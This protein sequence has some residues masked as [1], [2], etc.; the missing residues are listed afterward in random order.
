[1]DWRRLIRLAFLGA[2][3]LVVTSGLAL[4]FAIPEV[5]G[6]TRAS[7]AFLGLALGTLLVLHG[8]RPVAL[9]LLAADAVFALGILAARFG[10]QDRLDHSGCRAGIPCDARI[11][12]REGLRASVF[13]TGLG[14]AVAV[15]LAGFVR[16]RRSRPVPGP[17]V[18]SSQAGS[19]RGAPRL[20]G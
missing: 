15:A 7:L 19:G 10:V 3:L 8:L 5:S 13:L 14:L 17:Q 1:M 2:A 12:F 6:R 16:E 4:A 20:R 9:Y 18:P 11:D